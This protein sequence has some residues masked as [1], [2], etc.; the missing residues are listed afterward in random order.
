MERATR[1]YPASLPPDSAATR[2]VV[3]WRDGCRCQRDPDVGYLEP[4]VVAKAANLVP[5]GYRKPTDGEDVGPRE[6]APLSAVWARSLRAAI[7]LW[8][9]AGITGRSPDWAAAI[10][11]STNWPHASAIV[12]ARWIRL[13]PS[14]TARVAV[15]PESA[16]PANASTPAPEMV[17]RR[18]W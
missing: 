1:S 10:Q 13:A 2:R 4:A 15:L 17:R 16:F 18:R 9:T 14:K 8:S 11:A 5:D 6:S 3:N 12:V 7:S